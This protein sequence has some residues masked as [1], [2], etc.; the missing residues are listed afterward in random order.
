MASE[1]FLYIRTTMIDKYIIDIVVGISMGGGCKGCSVTRW[2]QVN[3]CHWIENKKEA[4]SNM[5]CRDRE[6]GLNLNIEIGNAGSTSIFSS[7]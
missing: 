7:G 1:A 2:S 3:V 6:C 5:F 4:R